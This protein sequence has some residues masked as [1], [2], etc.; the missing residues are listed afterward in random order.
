MLF[1]IEMYKIFISF[2]NDLK[3]IYFKTFTGFATTTPVGSCSDSFA[4]AG[5]EKS[6]LKVILTVNFLRDLILLRIQAR[7]A[8]TPRQSVGPTLAIIVRSLS[9][10]VASA[11]FTDRGGR[12]KLEKFEKFENNKIGTHC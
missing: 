6:P 9:F 7:Q 5:L 12:S 3:K 10:S 11:T 1:G 4:V 8:P 2:V